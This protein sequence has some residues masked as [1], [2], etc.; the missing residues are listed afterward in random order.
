MQCLSSLS[1]TLQTHHRWY[2]AHVAGGEWGTCI[3][4][5]CVDRLQVWPGVANIEWTME[6]LAHPLWLPGE[7]EP[8]HCGHSVI[9]AMLCQQ[10]CNHAIA[11][12]WMA[13]AKQVLAR[14]VLGW[15]TSLE[16]YVAA[17]SSVSDRDTV[18]LEKPSFGWDVKP[19]S[20]LT[21]A[22]KDSMTLFAKSRKF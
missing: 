7:A 9:A 4:S 13:D 6:T 8:H 18:R 20:R 14:L 16:D 22:I 2:S 17:G 15:V 19:K 1:S 12:C 11:S 10:P 21:V 3:P 5:L